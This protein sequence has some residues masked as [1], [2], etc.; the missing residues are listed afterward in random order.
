MAGGPGGTLGR[1]EFLNLL[2]TQ[3]QH[4]DPLEPME[5]TEFITQL[6]QFSEL[7]EVRNVSEEISKLSTQM[8]NLTDFNALSLLGQ[9]AEISGDRV[10]HQEGVPA[11]IRFELGSAADQ[12]MVT[13]YDPLG[14][15]VRDIALGDL[16]AG[17]QTVI[18][19]GRGLNGALL[20]AGT[21]RYSV[22][23]QDVGGNPVA[24]ETAERGEVKRVEFQNGLPFLLVGD[25]WLTVDAIRSVGVKGETGT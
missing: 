5:G 13:I 14:L 12:A 25:R 21:Y 23:A 7:D 10:F 15:A 6:A 24:V 17:D 9:E 8:A 20:P 19:D 4:Q 22:M 16:A 3:L 1:D 2:I 18:W 11:E